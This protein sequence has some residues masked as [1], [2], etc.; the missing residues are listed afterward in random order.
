VLAPE[1]R[2]EKMSNV[3]TKRNSLPRNITHSDYGF[4]SR[5]YVSDHKLE[6]EIPRAHSPTRMANPQPLGLRYQKPYNRKLQ[7]SNDTSN[8]NTF[9]I[10]CI[11]QMLHGEGGEEAYA[12][13]LNG[14]LPI[15]F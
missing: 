7:V 3:Y 5:H 14:F 13:S 6:R 4:K 11:L 12:S 9:H 10:S 8:D 15:A 1:V 2:Q